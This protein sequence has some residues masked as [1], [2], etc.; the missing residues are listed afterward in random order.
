MSEQRLEEGTVGTLVSQNSK[1][2]EQNGF[3]QVSDS[4]TRPQQFAMNGEWLGDGGP[5]IPGL[6]PWNEANCFGRCHP[7]TQRTHGQL[8]HGSSEIH[9]ELRV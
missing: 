1:G 9:R 8:S 2:L 6:C 7:R 5:E 4:G 3:Q